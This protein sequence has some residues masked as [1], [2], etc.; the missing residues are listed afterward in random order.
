VPNI[1]DAGASAK[2]SMLIHADIGW[3]KTSF[4]GS[5]GKDYKILLMRPPTDHVDPI[6]GSGVKEMIVRNWEEIFEGLEYVQHE[7]HHWDWFFLDSISLLQDIGLDDVYEGVLDRKG[8]VGSLARKDREQFGPDQGVY[9]VNMWRIGQWVRHMVGAGTVNL[10]IT[11]HSFYW[12][13]NDN[14]VTPPCIWP[15]IQGR[16]MPA[17]I[18]GMMNIVAFGSLQERE[19]RGKKRVARVLHT[20]AAEEY[21]AKCGFKLPDGSSPFG[22]TG[23]IIS[24]TLPGIMEALKAARPST[25]G[26]TIRRRTTRREQ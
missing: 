5:G 1:Q 19:H 25:N 22:P 26:R 15:W 20:N 8:P 21:Y 7:G 12:E 24:P 16:M 6:I 2:I 23:D 10:G 11:A 17:K 9:G 14:G 4:I 18:S 13:P 3:G